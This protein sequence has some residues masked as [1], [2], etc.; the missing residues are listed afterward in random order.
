MKNNRFV[1]IV[2][3]CALLAAMMLFMSCAP[4]VSGNPTPGAPT[5]STGQPT[6]KPHNTP[7]PTAAPELTPAPT[8]D[9]YWYLDLHHMEDSFPEDIELA[10]IKPV[11]TIPLGD[12]EREIGYK[13]DGPTII[14]ASTYYM[15]P[16]GRTLI[17]Y[18]RANKKFLWF[19]DQKWIKNTLFQVK[20]EELTDDPLYQDDSYINPSLFVPFD[21]KIL[22]SHGG[23]IS[24][25]NFISIDMDGMLLEKYDYP[26]IE[27]SSGSR[28]YVDRE[29]KVRYSVW[30]YPWHY[31]Y[32]FSKDASYY[33]RALPAFIVYNSRNGDY[34]Q[35]ND[36]N[37][38]IKY[39]LGK[40]QHEW[41]ILTS[42][43][44][45]YKV[46]EDSLFVDDSLNLYVRLYGDSEDTQAIVKFNK[47]GKLIGAHCLYEYKKEDGFVDYAGDLFVTEDGRAYML[48]V[49]MDRV[50]LQ[51]ILF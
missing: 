21:D 30:G 27:Y 9:Y 28:L 15:S 49:F 2:T 10:N 40:F 7:A 33:N 5:P 1:C 23:R 50:E 39:H 34:I 47:N 48:A 16:D 12:G 25:P 32:T 45:G 36:V 41:A 35:E 43:T 6:P 14:T 19:K 37:T 46:H 4:G 8:P 31:D 26:D 38:I 42:E 13:V 20:P 22:I 17:I 18:D 11:L 24:L 3:A 44:D 51:E 29:K